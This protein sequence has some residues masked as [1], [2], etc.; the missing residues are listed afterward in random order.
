MGNE[1]A[2]AGADAPAGFAA[3]PI[4]VNRGTFFLSERREL[5]LGCGYRRDKIIAPTGHEAWAGLVTVDINPSCGADLVADLGQLPYPFPDHHF[6]EIHA[7]EVM[8][9][10]GQQGD[11]RWFFAQFTELYRIAKPDGV[12]CM[13]FPHW[14]SPWAWGDPGHT[15]ILSIE[16]LGFLDRS[17]YDQVGA[18]PATD[19]R[20]WYG[21]DWRIAWQHLE[22][23]TRTQAV[24]LRAQ[25]ELL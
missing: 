20:P 3:D 17:F 22:A 1:H 15:R 24:M 12:L 13:T 5:L 14:T 10:I 7:Y 8:E 18:S 21:G 2:P 19:Y 11:W 4:D 16:A 6:D 9:H 25:K 23:N